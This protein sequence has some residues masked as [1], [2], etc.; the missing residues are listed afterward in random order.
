MPMWFSSLVA[1]WLD[2]NELFG[3][4]DNLGVCGLLD[5][6]G[7]WRGV[8]LFGG[9]PTNNRNLCVNFRRGARVLSPIGYPPSLSSMGYEL[10]GV[11]GDS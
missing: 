8:C 10:G 7:S 6:D 4:S 9:S 2:S 3:S 5:C 11:Y 1:G